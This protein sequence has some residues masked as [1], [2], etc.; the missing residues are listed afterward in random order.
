MISTG[1]FSVETKYSTSIS[2]VRIVHSYGEGI[3]LV[4]SSAL[5]GEE[6]SVS[7]DL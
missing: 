6:L 4:E 5:A 3:N 1:G 2:G 7:M